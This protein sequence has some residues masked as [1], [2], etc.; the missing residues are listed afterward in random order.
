MKDAFTKHP[1]GSR[2][3]AK[4]DGLTQG[5]LDQQTGTRK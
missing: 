2:V 1:N 3:N 4:T 5:G